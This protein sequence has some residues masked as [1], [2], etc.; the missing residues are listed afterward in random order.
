MGSVFDLYLPALTGSSVPPAEKKPG[1]FRGRGR[2]LVVDDD[3]I[4]LRAAG[5][6][7][8][9]MGFSVQGAADGQE[10]IDLYRQAMEAG[11]PFDA[12]IMDLTIP[13]GMGGMEAVGGLLKLD[14]NAKAIVSSGYADNPVMSRF[15][16]FGFSGAVAKPYRIEELGEVLKQVLE[17]G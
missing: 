16:E 6:A 8:R 14:P 1:L 5:E 7:I 2:V 3:E 17:A 15:R 13:G 4:I 9:R 10:G 11:A 12:V